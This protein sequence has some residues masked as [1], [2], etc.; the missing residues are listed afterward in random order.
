[1]HHDNTKRNRGIEVS[2][3]MTT[4]QACWESLYE[5]LGLPEK[6]EARG[7][8]WSAV[9]SSSSSWPLSVPLPQSDQSLQANQLD[10]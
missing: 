5:Y 6:R 4:Q 10:E 3:V 2:V 9:S 1:M 7:P 8:S